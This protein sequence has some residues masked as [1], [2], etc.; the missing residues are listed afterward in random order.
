MPE[1]RD[2]RIKRW[3]E[4]LVDH[5]RSAPEII[6]TLREGPDHINGVSVGAL[7]VNVDD[8]RA[9]IHLQRYLATFFCVG[10]AWPPQIPAERLLGH[11]S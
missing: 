1:E 8:S 6:D 11:P 5:R 10:A 7:L 2:E 3:F 4:I 9:A